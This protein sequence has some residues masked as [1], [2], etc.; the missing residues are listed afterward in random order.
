MCVCLRCVYHVSVCVC[1]LASQKLKMFYPRHMILSIREK[2]GIRWQAGVCDTI[3]CHAPSHTVLALT[4]S[5]VPPATDN[6]ITPSILSVII[7]HAFYIS[8][9][10][11]GFVFMQFH[12][13]PRLQR[14]CL[15]ERHDDSITSRCCR[16]N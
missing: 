2:L 12:D 7:L 1:V 11:N 6:R 4:R 9:T 13:V 15:E 10:P 14:G 5:G 8:R 3:F 16:L